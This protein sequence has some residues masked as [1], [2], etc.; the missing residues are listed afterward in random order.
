MQPGSSQVAGGMSDP[1]PG[2]CNQRYREAWGAYK[3]DLALY[4]PLDP[5][6]SR[7]EPP[8]LQPVEGGPVW[9][10][11]CTAA[12]RAQLGDL[13]DLAP[14]RRAGGDGYGT[15]TGEQ[16]VGGTKAAPSPSESGDDLDEVT[17]MLLGWEDA[18][19]DYKGWPSPP[20]RG[21]L[22][23]KRTSVTAWLA[24]HLDSILISPLAADFGAEVM[25]AHRDLKGKTKAGAR[26]IRKPLRCPACGL[27]TLLWDEAEPDD[28]ACGNRDCGAI[29]SYAVYEAT[30]QAR[31]GAA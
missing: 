20:R 21:F 31:V 19:R 6:Q 18:F 5:E 27:L 10:A 2:R 11:R 17:S 14:L 8:D 1:C 12:I 4:D 25:A 29:M 22:A 3:Q 13:D 15:S 23:D 16:R 26:K 28:V 24:D 7:P 30:V 9:C